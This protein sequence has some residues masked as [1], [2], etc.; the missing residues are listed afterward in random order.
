MAIHSLF[1]T[2]FFILKGMGLSSKVS[3]RRRA[4]LVGTVRIEKEFEQ[5][6]GRS[7]HVEFA[8]F[9]HCADK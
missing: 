6:L 7:V 5:Y 3:R 1:A 9:Y 8:E 4:K 2:G